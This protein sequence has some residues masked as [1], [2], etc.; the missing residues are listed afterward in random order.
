MSN[1]PL[2]SQ[3]SHLK[4]SFIF[5]V[6][7]TS[8]TAEVSGPQTPGFDHSCNGCVMEDQTSLMMPTYPKGQKKF[9]NTKDPE[10]KG[11]R[12]SLPLA[13]GSNSH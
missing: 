3:S 5:G 11:T 12:E 7:P 8:A 9:P 6:L 4:N 10:R 2:C 1:I 13:P